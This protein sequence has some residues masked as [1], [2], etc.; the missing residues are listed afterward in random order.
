MRSILYDY[1]DTKIQKKV[2]QTVHGGRPVNSF[3]PW[4]PSKRQV[5]ENGQFYVND[6][7]YSDKYPNSFFDIRYPNEDTAAK[8]PTLV[9]FHGGGCLFGDKSDG[10]PL[11]GSG[12]VTGLLSAICA[13]GYNVVSANYAF[14]TKYRFPVQIE[15]TDLLM[16]HL[17]DHPEYGLD[18]ENI[19]IG[20]GSA[21]ANITAIYGL[22]VADSDY[23]RKIGFTPCLMQ[24]QIKALVIDEMV[25]NPAHYSK[26]LM[27]LGAAWA[28]ERNLKKGKKAQL[29]NIVN[30]FQGKF[31]PAFLTASNVEPPFEK[32]ATEMYELLQKSGIPSQI[33]Y[34]SQ[35]ESEPLTHGFVAAFAENKYAKEAFDAITAFLQKQVGP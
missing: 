11:A 2:F 35:A 7:C 22:M 31:P 5:C 23:A 25:L 9:Y 26:G 33:Y 32:C 27:I 20:G 18:M 14:A 3:E 16:A 10:D 8:R 13:L 12:G 30:H 24:E 19:I 17:L 34:R 4:Q 21:G 29:G 6:L 15:Q 28:G 1:L